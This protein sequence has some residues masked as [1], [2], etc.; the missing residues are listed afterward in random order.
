MDTS[1]S[2]PDGPVKLQPANQQIESRYLA[3]HTPYGRALPAI[4]VM[5]AKS[6]TVSVSP[7][8]PGLTPA[9]VRISA[10][11]S[12]PP[13]Q[14][15]RAARRVLRRWAKAASTSRNMA[16]RSASGVG[17]RVRRTSAEST[18]GTGQKTL[19]GT[20]ATR[21]ASAYQAILT[22]GTP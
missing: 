13:A 11:W 17:R 21:R 4:R 20:V 10:A 18:L 16:S 14:V 7:R 12:A 9:R 19:R 3:D 15:A 1:S 22:L 8:A 2:T 5:A 6:P